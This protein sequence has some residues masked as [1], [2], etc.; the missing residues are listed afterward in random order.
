M[1]GFHSH[2][3]A[4]VGRIPPPTRSAHCQLT[5]ARAVAAPRAACMRSYG[6]VYG[7]LVLL[8]V[9]TLMPWNVFITEKEFWDVRLHQDPFNPYVAHNFMSLFAI[10]FNVT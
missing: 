5:H 3:K 1:G 7:I 4:Q 2:Q 10:V 8:G 6:L 9:G